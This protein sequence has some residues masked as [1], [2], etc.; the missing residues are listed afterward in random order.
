MV[1]KLAMPKLKQG[2]VKFGIQK[3]ESI[4][5][6]YFSYLCRSYILSHLSYILSRRSQER[7]HTLDNVRQGG[8]KP[9]D[10]P[11]FGQAERTPVDKVSGSSCCHRIKKGQRTGWHH[12]CEVL[13]SALFNTV[14]SVSV[15]NVS[16]AR[17]RLCHI[18]AVFQE[19]DW[20]HFLHNS[21]DYNPE[22]G[23]HATNTK[24]DCIN[25]Q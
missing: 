9:P 4:Y 6:T 14:D 13:S 1:R 22:H 12:T 17:A 24:N 7:R 5:S 19:A 3:S 11:P 21:A 8:F 23:S 25:P 18:S 20:I 10:R 2:S 15:C 16:D